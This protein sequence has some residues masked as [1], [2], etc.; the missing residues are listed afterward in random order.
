M[1]LDADLSRAAGLSDEGRLLPRA[2][3]G[4]LLRC[5]LL[6]LVLAVLLA[7]AGTAWYVHRGVAQ[8]A[9]TRASDQQTDE[10]ELVARLLAARG[11][12]QQKVLLTLADAMPLSRLED[13]QALGLALHEELPLVDWF[14]SVSVALADGR[15]MAYMR[16]GKDLP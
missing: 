2:R 1:A 15:L 9:L 6:L 16:A 13:S 11:E 8:E 4:P 10:V 7:S 12:Q 3:L 14:D 5:L